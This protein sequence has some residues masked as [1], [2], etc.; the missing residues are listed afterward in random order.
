MR[1][2]SY[3]STINL[4]VG[5]F[6]STV[7]VDLSDTVALGAYSTATLSL[8]VHRNY[9]VIVIYVEHCRLMSPSLADNCRTY[10]LIIIQYCVCVV[11]VRLS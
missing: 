6:D 4:V 7:Y 1:V 10:S 9:A 3:E 11:F 8:Y 2:V 5:L